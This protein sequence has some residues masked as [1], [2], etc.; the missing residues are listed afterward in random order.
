MKNSEKTKIAMELSKEFIADWFK[1]IRKKNP[2]LYES[3]N[4]VMFNKNIP[5]RL[6]K[7]FQRIDERLY[8]E[9]KF[10]EATKKTWMPRWQIDYL[11]RKK[12]MT[13]SEILRMK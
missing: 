1:K 3:I 5:S 6:L 12:W 11:F 2:E 9:D 7:Y 4:G 13:F 8:I 10:N